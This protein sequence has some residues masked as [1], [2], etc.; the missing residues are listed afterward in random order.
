MPFTGIADQKD[1][2]IMMEALDSYC[3]ERGIVDEDSRSFTAQRIASLFFA[4]V[5]TVEEIMAAL[6]STDGRGGGVGTAA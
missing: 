1:I 5:S 3:R 4:G 6:R 2:E